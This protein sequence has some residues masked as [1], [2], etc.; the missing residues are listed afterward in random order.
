M[1]TDATI[2]LAAPS[3]ASLT[4]ILGRYFQRTWSHGVGHRLYDTAGKAYLDFANSIV[5]EYTG[6]DVG[7][8]SSSFAF[9]LIQPLLRNAGRAV[10]LESLTQS[11]RAVLYSVRSF[12]RFR[13]H[14]GGLLPADGHAT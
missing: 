2:D 7:R 12:A 4:P 13:D 5:Y 8:V 1:P 9:Q 10:R 11:E 6:Q 3:A 14:S